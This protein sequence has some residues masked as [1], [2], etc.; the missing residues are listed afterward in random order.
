[1]HDKDYIEYLID[2]IKKEGGATLK[3]GKIVTYDDGYQVALEGETI[4]IDSDTDLLHHI[5]AVYTLK[6]DC[7]VWENEEGFIEIDT[8]S[9]H[10]SGYLQAMSLAEK[11]NQK[12]IYD[13]KRGETLEVK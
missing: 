3:G 8:T 6:L 4:V 7:G 13:W 12:A 10:I 1:M 2:T 9:V 11:N 5:I